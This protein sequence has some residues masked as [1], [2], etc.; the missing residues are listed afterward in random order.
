MSEKPTLTPAGKE[1][2]EQELS[3]LLEKRK[4][5]ID[6]IAK[7]K[8]LGDLSENAEYHAAREEQAFNEG[9]IQE[10]E[11]TLKNAEVVKEMSGSSTVQL[12]SKVTVTA[13]GKD[14]AYIIVGSNETSIPEN[15][16]SIES[17]VAKALLD[18][19]VGDTV[20]VTLPAG[21]KKYTVK[22]IE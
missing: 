8:E 20:Q 7:A 4:D 13:S 2:L 12:G 1:K 10:L 11:H 17:P 22:A 9:K 3:G 21:T 5:I 14:I 16:I 6:R 19:S 18:A 15:K